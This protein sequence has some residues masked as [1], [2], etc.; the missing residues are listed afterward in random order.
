MATFVAVAY[1]ISRGL[2]KAGS[3]EPYTEDRDYR[4]ACKR[5]AESVRRPVDDRAIG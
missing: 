5:C 3:R 1:I 4:S 2:A